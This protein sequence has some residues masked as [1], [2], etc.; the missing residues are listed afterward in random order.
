MRLLDAFFRLSVFNPNA[1]PKL[2]WEHKGYGQFSYTVPTKYDRYSI[3]IE[4]SGA[5]GGTNS[6]ALLADYSRHVAGNGELCTHIF[7]NANSNIISGILGQ[8]GIIVGSSSEANGGAGYN[9]GAAGQLNN[10]YLWARAGGGGGSSSLLVD[11][12]FILE[13]SA[14]G[15]ISYYGLTGGKGAGPKGGGAET[16]AGNGLGAAGAIYTSGG[17]AENKPGEDGYIKVYILP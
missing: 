10:E 11:G 12:V 8:T 13:A 6:G 16:S 14:G 4:I 3:M 2:I 5:G 17:G 15:G 7:N 1:K 9:K